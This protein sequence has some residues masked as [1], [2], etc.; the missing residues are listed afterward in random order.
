MSKST[1]ATYYIQLEPTTKGIT[2]GIR[3]EFGDVGK[4]GGKSLGD[5][6]KSKLASA[7]GAIGKA[8]AAAVG[9]SIGAVSSGIAALTSQAVKGYA[10]Y[11]QLKGGV[12]TLFKDSAKTV[13]EYASSAYKTAGLT[14]NEY[15]D[16]VT[17][18]SAS[19]ISSLGGETEKAADYANRAITDMADNANKM[20][21]SIE[22]IQNAYQG[23]AKQNYTMLDNL[24]LGYG[25][26]KSEME[27]LIADAA[28]MKDIQT[29]LGITI[30]E[31]SMSFDN[32]V[33][34]ISVMQTH[35]G[36]AGATSAE[37][38][39]TIQGSFGAMKAAWENLVTGM[40]DDKADMGG[41]IDNLLNSVFGE[42]EGEGFLN[43][44][45]PRIEIAVDGVGKFLEKAVP[46]VFKKLP[47][48]VTDVL[49]GM[50]N[51]VT[52]TFNALISSAPDILT[53]ATDVANTVAKEIPGLVSTLLPAIADLID[54][55]GK[56]LPEIL[57]TIINVVLEVVPTILEHLPEILSSIITLIENVVSYILSDGLPKIIEIL[58][59]LIKGIVDF[60]TKGLPMIAEAV[61][62]IINVIVENLPD[63]IVGL[64]EAIPEI[65]TGIVTGLLKC[66]PQLISALL[67]L[68]ILSLVGVPLIIAEIVERIPEIITGIV[69]GFKD[70]WPAMKQAGIDAFEQF[71]LASGDSVI[72]S[73]AASAVGEFFENIL[74]NVTSWFGNVKEEFSLGIQG[75]IGAFT[76]WSESIIAAVEEFFQP[77]V[78]AILTIWNWFSATFGPLLEALRN[79][80]SAVFEAILVI[81]T[82]VW[83]SIKNLILDYIWNPIVTLVTAYIE[84]VKVAVETGFNFIK[85]KIFTP[86]QAVWEK[87]QE[88]WMNVSNKFMEAINTIHNFVAEKFEAIRSKIEEP[89]QR[90]K[91]KVTEIFNGIRDTIKGVV[92]QAVSWGRDL[93]GNIISGITEK[94][95]MLTDTI[96]GVANS[97][98][99]RIHFSEPDI[100]PLADFHTY[101][102]DMMKLFAQ[103]IRENEKIVTDQIDRSF[104]FG[105][106]FAMDYQP[107]SQPALAGAGTGGGMTVVEPIYIGTQLIDELVLRVT[108]DHIYRSGGR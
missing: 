26:T 102:P 92:D 15:M 9:A 16:T 25:G 77:A 2:D 82:N 83:T 10:E 78:D 11:E 106:I 1:L 3:K 94:M 55:I 74:A 38:S 28:E 17:S 76:E 96:N 70:N 75:A 52:D 103:G 5:S 59:D 41:L 53:M 40:A 69:N 72:I 29:E 93:I 61:V 21:T 60:I 12:E 105:Q 97:I 66:A 45:L 56:A 100:G 4:E 32:I 62:T 30:D 48:I 91:D 65:I 51:A 71:V 85:D 86:L 34:A 7:A 47:E 39:T 68:T 8:T 108:Q 36:I 49:P 37:A 107:V 23:F 14:A 95:S 6:V 18:F 67:E 104:D 89:L 81:A 31:N 90:A 54:A 80:V 13:M 87:V 98:H 24:K 19:L 46:R 73:E 20:G 44:I 63:L 42:K 27:R 64:I 57:D 79:L 84:T 88:V 50:L 58:P 33:S 99:E 43:N 101:A 35:L 22:S